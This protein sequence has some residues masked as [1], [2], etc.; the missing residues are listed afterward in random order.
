M[1]VFIDKKSSFSRADDPEEK[2]LKKT[3]V[4]HLAFN[5]KMTMTINLGGVGGEGEGGRRWI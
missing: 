5:K 2:V 1:E 3:T 4:A